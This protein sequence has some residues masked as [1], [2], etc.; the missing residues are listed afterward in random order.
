MVHV[1][2]ERTETQDELWER[3]QRYIDNTIE[4][5]DGDD[6]ALLYAGDPTHGTK[7]ADAGL[8][9]VDP[10]EQVK[11]AAE[12][13]YPWLQHRNVRVMRF[14]SGT[15]SH[16]RMGH[17]LSGAAV[18]AMILE[19]FPRFDVDSAHHG[20][21][22]FKDK[23]FDIAHHGPSK[24]SRAWLEGNVARYYLRDRMIRDDQL[25]KDPAHVYLRGHFHVWVYEVLSQLFHGEEYRSILTVLPSMCGMSDYARQ[26]TKSEMALTNGIV[27]YEVIE[28]E[29]IRVHPFKDTTD[30]RVEE[31]VL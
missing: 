15:A 19:D 22:C 6:I 13:V 30:L 18:A 9:E 7:Y 5:A 28:G 16:V 1:Y 26:S 21:I 3:Y 20:R 12:S 29:P 11:I 31:T 4:L 24:G 25:G 2:P 17:T 14:F 8:M 23:V 27:A 10:Y